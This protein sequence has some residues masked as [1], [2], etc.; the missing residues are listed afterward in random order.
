[1]ELP[2]RLPRRLAH[3]GPSDAGRLPGHGG[4]PA[5]DRG[6]RHVHHDRHP[7]RPRH[8]GRCPLPARRLADDPG[9][10]PGGRT[11]PPVVDRNAATFLADAECVAAAAG[12]RR[13]AGVHAGAGCPDGAGPGGRPAFRRR[14]DRVFAGLDQ[15]HQRRL[16]GQPRGRTLW[17]ARAGAATCGDG[18][19]AAAGRGSPLRRRRPRGA[20]RL[21]RPARVGTRRR[22]DAG[23]VWRGLRLGSAAAHALL[24]RPGRHQPDCSLRHAGAAAG[25]QHAARQ[26]PAPDRGKPVAA[27]RRRTPGSGAVHSWPTAQPMP[28]TRR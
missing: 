6:G 24:R 3:G 18:V 8:R 7:G 27:D 1:M 19:P 11:P 17:A 4:M 26:S 20:I 16:A 22:R 21:D 10:L 25:H 28:G 2:R 14:A 13:G 15:A 12:H 5:A 9:R 23:P